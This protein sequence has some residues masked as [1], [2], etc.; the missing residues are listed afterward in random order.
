MT[1]HV[2]SHSGNEAEFEEYKDL[3]QQ[4]SKENQGNK[5][6]N[7]KAGVFGQYNNLQNLISML[8]PKSS[9]KP[10]EGIRGLE[11]KKS[12]KRDHSE[13]IPV[14]K[15]P[16]LEE[17]KLQDSKNEAQENESPLIKRYKS[18]KTFALESTQSDSPPEKSEIEPKIGSIRLFTA[19][20]QTR[21]DIDESKSKIEI[22]RSFIEPV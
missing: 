5:E 11:R 15:K 4:I 8:S 21:S 18:K 1:S 20:D 17:S 6:S 12:D 3:A 2:G 7:D 13:P 16:F 19:A 14:F 10:S 22:V 9:A